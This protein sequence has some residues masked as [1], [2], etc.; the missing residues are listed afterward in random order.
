LGKGRFSSGEAGYPPAMTVRVAFAGAGF[1][2]A[3]HLQGS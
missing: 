1:I 2:A 3:R